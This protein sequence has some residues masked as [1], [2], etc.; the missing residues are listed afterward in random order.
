MHW[1]RDELSG[2]ALEIYQKGR[3]WFLSGFS[4][5][6][7]NNIVPLGVYLGAFHDGERYLMRVIRSWNIGKIAGE[8]AVVASSRK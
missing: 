7:A 5:P 3:A 1:T 8:Y 4:A 2:S 6:S